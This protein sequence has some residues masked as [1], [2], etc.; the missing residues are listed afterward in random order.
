MCII[1]YFFLGYLTFNR[2]ASRKLMSKCR[3][4]YGLYDLVVGNLGE[5]GRLSKEFISEYKRQR[6][7][8]IPISPKTSYNRMLIL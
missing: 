8:G 2:T 5:D 4:K 1:L 3:G 6:A 7:V